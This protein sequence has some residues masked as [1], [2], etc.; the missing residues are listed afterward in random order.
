MFDCL[1]LCVY[2]VKIII[3]KSDNSFQEN[4]NANLE[5]KRFLF[6][7]LTAKVHSY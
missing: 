6:W 5:S 3:E 7:K 1:C 2:E 4:I